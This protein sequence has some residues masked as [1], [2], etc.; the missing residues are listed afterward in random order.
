M[1]TKFR[2]SELCNIL[3]GNGCLPAVQPRKTAERASLSMLPSETSHVPE[4]WLLLEILSQ[5]GRCRSNEGG[6]QYHPR[7]STSMCAHGCELPHTFVC[8]HA[9]ISTH[10]HIHVKNGEE[11]E[12]I[13]TALVYKC[14]FGNY[15]QIIFI[16][17]FN[18]SSPVSDF[19]VS[20]CLDLITDKN[21]LV[22]ESKGS[23]YWPKLTATSK[24]LAYFFLKT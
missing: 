4:L 1:R 12:T 22:K 10:M 21:Q 16:D 20:C 23:A 13:N 17:T 7:P 8:T 19:T 24:T 3:A 6:F 14:T 11:C 18:I 15:L 9:N 2:P 5:R